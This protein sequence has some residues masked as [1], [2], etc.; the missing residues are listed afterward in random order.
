M[1]TTPLYLAGAPPEHDSP[2]G[3]ALVADD[4]HDFRQMLVR[5]AR[6]MGLTVVE[7]EDGDQAIA[8]LEQYPF[9][10]IVLDVYMPGSDGLSVF[11]AARRIDP[12]I[13]AIVLTGSASV[14]NAVEAL[15]GGV[16]D[17][18]TKP[19]ESLAAFEL[20]LARALEYRHLLR[21]NARLFSEVQRLAVTDSLTGLYNRHKLNETL[22]VEVERAHRYSRPL[23]IIM[24]DMD[25]L[26]AVNDNHGHQAGDSVLQQAAQAVR[27]QVRRVDTAT[28][29]GGDEFVVLL[30]EANG[31][32]A[33]R[34]AGRIAARIL[35][36]RI[37]GTP[38]SASLG[39]A[40]WG[41]QFESGK[42]F[43]AAADAALY[44]AK[45][46][47]RGRVAVWDPE[48]T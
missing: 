28:R 33:E 7:A 14:E 32:E 44:K 16:Y 31:E 46:T 21:E 20:S 17:F 25:G 48:D 10:V 12:D 1:D 11:A 22:D 23:S 43:L 42:D 9:D 24:I 15:R 5:R 8:A 47:G 45:R 29:F 26:K 41:P 4:D 38:V 39:V 19:I 18:L 27:S 6:K 37:D 2:I 35:A 13:Q 40:A 3:L 34:V 30:P 36:I